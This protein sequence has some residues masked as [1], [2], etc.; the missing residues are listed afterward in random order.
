MKKLF[1]LA[2][3]L[4]ILGVATVSV[5]PTYAATDQNTSKHKT[6]TK[7]VAKTESINFKTKKQDDPSLPAGQ[8]KVITQGKKGSKKV[9]YKI[10]YVDGKQ[11]KKKVL[12]SKV[13]KQP[14]TKVVAV[15]TY[16]APAPAPE[17][18]QE[19]E[20]TPQASSSCDPNYSGAC[21]PIASDV[22]CAGGSGNGPAYVQGPV[23]VI[24]SDIYGL[25][26][27]GNG[28]GCEN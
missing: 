19:P 13:T 22:D 21:V 6:T 18:E 26:R 2:I 10:T 1:L 8:T 28:I 4:S 9:K 17:P 3:A 25:D 27:D 24:G 16:V 5:T 15:G 11:T 23:T 12:S 20:P 14:V 7:T